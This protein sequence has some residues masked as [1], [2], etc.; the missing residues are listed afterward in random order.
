MYMHIMY[1]IYIF[2][3]SPRYIYSCTHLKKKKGFSAELIRSCMEKRDLLR[4]LQGGGVDVVFF[5]V[6]SLRERERQRERERERER[7]L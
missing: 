5:L 3:Y 2:M 4:L 6:H 1:I 7:A